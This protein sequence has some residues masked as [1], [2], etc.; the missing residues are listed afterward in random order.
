MNPWRTAANLAT[1]AN[2]LVGVGAILYVVL[3]NP[4]FSL[5]LIVIGVGFD[6]LDGML[7]RRAG[8][9]GRRSGRIADSVADAITFGLAPAL[10]IGYHAGQPS[11][12]MVAVPAAVVAALYLA[13]ALVR[14]IRFTR[15]LHSRPHFVGAPTPMAAIAIAWLGVALYDPA[16]FSV[17]PV[18]FL[19]LAVPVALEMV[20]PWPFP[21]IRRGSALRV[22][23]AITGIAAALSLVPFQFRPAPGSPIYLLAMGA[24]AVWAGGLAVYYLLGPRSAGAGPVAPGGNGRREAGIP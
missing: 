20:A 15:S 21:K 3:G 10:V 2:A 24:A 13:L 22:P 9:A 12:G 18:L 17:Q 7:S 6:G 1:L 4:L 8:G 16:F 5:L 23:M 11:W 14:L 19:G